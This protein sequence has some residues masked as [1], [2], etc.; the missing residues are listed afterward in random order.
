M[1]RKSQSLIAILDELLNVFTTIRDRCY[2]RKTSHGQI[3][4]PTSD[5]SISSS[6]SHNPQL[7]QGVF[8]LIWDNDVLSETLGTHQD[9][10]YIAEQL[11]NTASLF[12]TNTETKV[13]A[14]E[15]FAKAHDFALLSEEEEGKGLSRGFLDF[16]FGTDLYSLAPFIN[17]DTPTSETEKAC[18]LSSEFSAQCLLLAVASVVDTF[19]GRKHEGEDSGI[20]SHTA[21]IWK[22]IRRLEYAYCEI[23]VNRSEDYTECD[24]RFKHLVVLLAVCCLVETGDDIQSINFLLACGT[25]KYIYS[26]CAGGEEG[27]ISEDSARTL[28]YLYSCAKRAEEKLMRQTSWTLLNLTCG[29]LLH[30]RR[31]QA[32]IE[33]QDKFYPTLGA[34][35]QKLVQTAP[36]VEKALTIFGDVNKALTEFC[37]TQSENS[38]C[39]YSGQEIDW[40]TVESYNRGINLVFLGDLDNAE[41]LITLA[42]NFLHHCTDEVKMHGP[43]MRNGYMGVIKRKDGCNKPSSVCSN[44]VVRLF[45]RIH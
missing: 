39:L 38:T 15:L 18:D 31:F 43:E 28:A 26:S 5:K 42:L 33:V 35:Q 4:R 17:E 22:S 7:E 11:W 24:D 32:R 3:R 29:E 30:Q 12:V 13:I 25:N 45:S 36:S 16:D 6:H 19:T 9:C 27:T 37:G 2:A 1:L 20:T 10:V 23:V 14:A 8:R 21:L 44:S 40:F 41:R 34:M